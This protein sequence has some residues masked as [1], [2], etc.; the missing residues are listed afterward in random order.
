MGPCCSSGP[1]CDRYC[2]HSVGTE[3]RSLTGAVTG[4]LLLPLA[5]YG[6]P[7]TRASE[8]PKPD[9][10]H[11]HAVC[12]QGTGHRTPEK[13]AGGRP[14]CLPCKLAM[15]LLRAPHLPHPPSPT[16]AQDI[17]RTVLPSH[18]MRAC[19]ATIPPL[20]LSSSLVQDGHFYICSLVG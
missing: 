9:L 16:Q 18:S 15:P 14:C 4:M 7:T 11:Q 6:P 10:S 5:L 13:M 3:V 8:L 12:H 1:C 17:H 2:A 20:S 19:I